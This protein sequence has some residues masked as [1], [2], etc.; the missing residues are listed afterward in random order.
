[1]LNIVR[2]VIDPHTQK[3]ID[4]V[5]P[6][7]LNGWQDNVHDTLKYSGFLDRGMQINM[8]D[9]RFCSHAST[10]WERSKSFASQGP[11]FLQKRM[12]FDYKTVDWMKHQSNKRNNVLQHSVPL[13]QHES[14]WG[15][16]QCCIC[17]SN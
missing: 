13:E 10:I 5:L 16:H 2:G 17:D 3:L 6:C 14:P 8:N 15:G 7:E 9:G 11:E 12:H 4:F 1:M